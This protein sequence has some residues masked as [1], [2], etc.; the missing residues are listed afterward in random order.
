MPNYSISI[1]LFRNQ[2]VISDEKMP[3]FVSKDIQSFDGRTLNF[4]QILSRNH[5]AAEMGFCAFYPH[6]I[7][8][9]GIIGRDEMS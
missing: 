9:R 1:N 3:F 2:K 5:L 8:H 6:L 7:R 4:H